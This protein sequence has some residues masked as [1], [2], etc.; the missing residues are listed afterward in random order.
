MLLV[1]ALYICSGGG[2]ILLHYLVESLDDKNISYHLLCDSRCE[3]EFKSKTNKTVLV[4]KLTT[5]YNFYRMHKNDYS[6][7]LCFANIPAPINLSVPV[8]TYFHNINLLTL[9]QTNSK[10]NYVMSWFKRQLFRR[11][12]GNTNFWVVQTSN[13]K[14][15]LVNHLQEQEHRVMIYPFFYLPSELN[16]LK[17]V[18]G[19]K[20]YV[21]VGNYYNGAK[22]HDELLDAWEILFDKGYKPVLH[23]TVDHSNKKVCDRIDNMIRR[24][25]NVI[26]HGTLPFEKI[27]RL[28]SISKA[29]IYP[30]HNESLG[31]GIVEAVSSG[32]DVIGTDLPY[33][34]AICK[35]TLTFRAYSA[36]SIADAVIEYEKGGLDKSKLTISNQ[37]NDFIEILSLSE[38]T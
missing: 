36:S 33:T 9:N 19:R 26:N 27:I 14:K 4:A 29:T 18:L 22:G 25:V 28:Y 24:G 35:P 2:L 10:R 6:S 7:V 5:R 3:E 16:N 30:S 15:E 17:D 38:I 1:D 8:Y 32:L 13:T 11:L 20:D 34:Y 21:F 23:L 12:K 37:I 31:L